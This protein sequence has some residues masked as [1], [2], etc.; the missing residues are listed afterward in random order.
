MSHRAR[1]E[2]FFDLLLV[3]LLIGV[4]GCQKQPTRAP[5][6]GAGVGRTGGET[7]PTPGPT[8]EP[9]VQIQA[10]P[11]TLRAGESFT[12]SWSS[13]EAEHLTIDSGV[14]S[15]PTSGSLKI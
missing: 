1:M 9:T 2:W 4:C 14:G 12:L 10:Q 7:L 6:P 5:T 15:V 3:V 13:T 11:S 8:K